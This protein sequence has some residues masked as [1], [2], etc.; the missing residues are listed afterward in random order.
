M[1]KLFIGLMLLLFSLRTGPVDI[2][3]SLAGAL[4][5]VTGLWHFH[6]LHHRLQLA[7]A[8]GRMALLCAAL[9][10][11]ML[12]SPLW[13]VPLAQ[14]G[15]LLA[16]GA[17]SFGLLYQLFHGFGALCA[18]AEP[19]RCPRNLT[20][21][22]LLFG[23]GAAASL[24]PVY[25][26][27]AAFFVVP[28]S[29]VLFLLVL[30]K[31]IQLATALDRRRKPLGERRLDR[32]YAVQLA[33]FLLV[34]GLFTGGALV[35]FNR[36][37]VAAQVVQTAETGER[38]AYDRLAELGLP[39]D[40]LEDLPDDELRHYA[41][42]RS[43]QQA[44][45]EWEEDGGRLRLTLYATGLP[46]GRVRLLTV[47]QWLEP[48]RHRYVERLQVR[49]GGGM[50]PDG[51]S[52]ASRHLYQRPVYEKTI[53]YAA[54]PLRT[55]PAGDAQPRETFPLP[56]KGT[57]LRGYLAFTVRPAAAGTAFDWQVQAYYTHQSSI[58]NLPYRDPFTADKD[59]LAFHTGTAAGQWR[60]TAD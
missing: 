58:G 43:L 53:P 11:V 18:Q 38:A 31:F 2:A 16:M 7:Y 14:G 15:L 26:G 29:A 21:F 17:A 30:L 57:A 22:A 10:A 12:A 36:P 50:V 54:A 3:L 34:M 23:I 27:Q 45:N 20:I 1:V 51:T 47:Y 13:T 55:S 60:Y 56:S 49:L 33:A 48:P 44:A 28:L 42:A 46:D 32:Y 5:T 40:L 59:S 52:P 4:L 25:Y 19:E 39:K 6:S 35:F 37:A 24:L 9:R 41:R 8:F